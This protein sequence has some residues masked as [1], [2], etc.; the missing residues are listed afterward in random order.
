[1]HSEMN[2]V[3]TYVFCHPSVQTRGQK[4]MRHDQI[5]HETYKI[6][7]E[8]VIRVLKNENNKQSIPHENKSKRE[9]RPR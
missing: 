7:E 8:N 6:Q 3:V 2:S 5:D 4:L 1:M 9:R